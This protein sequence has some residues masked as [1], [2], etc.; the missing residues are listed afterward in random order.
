MLCYIRFLSSYWPVSRL[1][2]LAAPCGLSTYGW[3]CICT[4]CRTRILEKWSFQEIILKMRNLKRADA[5]HMVKQHQLSLVTGWFHHKQP[6]SLDVSTTDLLR[7]RQSGMP[8]K[9]SK[10]CSNN[11]PILTSCLLIQKLAACQ[12]SEN[13]SPRGFSL[14][15][16]LTAG[17][18]SPHMNFII[19]Q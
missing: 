16:S 5:C 17:T 8:T 2:I 10:T 18:I 3:T 6:P 1:S 13:Q 19:H 12:F 15:V 14:L 4:R 11:L 7:R 9:T